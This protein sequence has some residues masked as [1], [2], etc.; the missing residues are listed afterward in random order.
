MKAMEKRTTI[1]TAIAMA[2]EVELMVAGGAVEV[3]DELVLNSV[4]LVLGDL[5][6]AVMTVDGVFASLIVDGSGC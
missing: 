3:D 5:E 6:G 4:L 2:N 1:G